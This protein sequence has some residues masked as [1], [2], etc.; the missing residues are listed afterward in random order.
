MYV[1]VPDVLPRESLDLVD[2]VPMVNDS[3]QILQLVLVGYVWVELVVEVFVVVAFA[4]VA[5]DVEVVVDAY[6]D[7][8]VDDGLAGDLSYEEEA[9]DHQHLLC[10]YQAVY[11]IRP[12][13][14]L[15]FCNNFVHIMCTTFSHY[16]TV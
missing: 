8:D 9:E 4:V 5:F 10:R 14:N 15:L 11:F 1:D 7:Y 13:D 6:L 12:L 2:A 16:K 3:R